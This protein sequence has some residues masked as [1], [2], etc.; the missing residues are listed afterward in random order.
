MSNKLSTKKSS[1]KK[2]LLK[3]IATPA[4]QKWYRSLPRGSRKLVANVLQ[5]T[6]SNIS[7]IFSGNRNIRL[8]HAIILSAITDGEISIKELYPEIAESFDIL[9]ALA[10][11][12]KLEAMRV[13]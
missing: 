3:H 10:V 5:L 11:K 6:E 9:V 8:Q 12:E 2:S 4:V 7:A 1:T 13:A